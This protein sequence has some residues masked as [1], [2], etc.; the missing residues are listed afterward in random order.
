MGYLHHSNYIRIYE[1]ARW[2]LFREKGIT[3]K[4]IEADGY[5]LPVIDL[6][7][8]YKLSAHYDDLLRVETK[9]EKC[10]GAKLLFSHEIFNEDNKLI[11]SSQLSVCFVNKENRKAIRVPTYIYD[12]LSK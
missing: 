9:L 8:T 10:I 6:S 7:V 12:V 4:Q 2:E 5:M 3:Y 1:S 11:N